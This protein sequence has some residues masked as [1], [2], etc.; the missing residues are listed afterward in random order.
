MLVSAKKILLRTQ[1]FLESIAPHLKDEDAEM[2]RDMSLKIGDIIPSV[3][4]NIV[5]VQKRHASEV[6]NFRK[7][8]N[9]KNL[10][11]ISRELQPLN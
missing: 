7:K 8:Q 4:N 2:I 1:I 10:A 5:N 3:E 11:D 6:K 9:Y